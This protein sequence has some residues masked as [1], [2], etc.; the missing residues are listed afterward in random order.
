M[1][2]NS[3][4]QAERIALLLRDITRRSNAFLYKQAQAEDLTMPQFLLMGQVMRHPE[5][6][7]SR[8]SEYLGLSKSTVVGIID[9]L[10]Q[11]GW[12]R[13]ERDQADRRSIRLVPTEKALQLRDKIP[14]ATSQYLAPLL[15][16]LPAQKVRQLEES[17]ALLVEIS[18]GGKEC[19]RGV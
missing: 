10:E 18:A 14:A 5:T 1:A 9:R 19:G 17:L 7:L 2:S 11:R 8:A 6:T 16:Q 15:E 3:L 12:L 4:Q 13:R